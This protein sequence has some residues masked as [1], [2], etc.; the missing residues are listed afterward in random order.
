MCRNVDGTKREPDDERESDEGCGER[1]Q[2]G[3]EGW[4]D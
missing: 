1:R 4:K 2:D 3:R